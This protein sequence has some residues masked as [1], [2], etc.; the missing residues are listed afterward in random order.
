M[1]AGHEFRLPIHS[2]VDSVTRKFPEK[3]HI[4]TQ[5]V[6]A[7]T[8]CLV[9]WACFATG[10]SD[11]T[12]V[13]GDAVIN[14]THLPQPGPIADP[15]AAAALIQYY[16][17]KNGSDVTGNGSLVN[18]WRTIN[19]AI[20]VLS[21]HGARHGGVCINVRP[22]IYHESVNIGS[23]YYNGYT[24]RNGTLVS[25]N[26][27]TPRG[28]FVLRSTVRHGATIA[29][30]A[31]YD[32]SDG[33][34]FTNASY[35]VVDGFNIVGNDHAPNL[36]A[37]GIN[38]AGS[39]ATVNHSSH[40][41]IM[42]N[43]VHGWGLAGIAS[44]HTDY[45]NVEGNVV[46]GN[47]N[48]SKWGGSGIGVNW[49]P[50]ALN[51]GVWHTGS[52]A[53]AKFHNIVRNNA[54]FHNAEVNIQGQ[55]HW[56][57]N[58][59]ILDGFNANQGANPAYRQPTLVENNVTAYNGGA[60]IITGG[61]GASYVT[62]RNNTSFNNQLDPANR[63]TIRGEIAI[64]GNFG[65]SSHNDIVVNN[66]AVANPKLSPHDSAYV[67]A[68]V[69]RTNP[70]TNNT[71]ACNLSFNGTTGQASI[72][73]VNTTSTFA[74]AHG[75]IPGRNPLFANTARNNFT[76]RNGSPAIGSGTAAYGVPAVDFLGRLRSGSK[77]MGAYSQRG[78]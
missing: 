5:F 17:A 2:I 34:S 70:N 48:T 1:S 39:S 60:G 72:A 27:D 37:T 47:S 3:N 10:Y 11:M 63:A 51:S 36:N 69:S 78:H 77:D 76:L 13:A 46:Y 14:S 20:D 57:G 54:S 38:F 73:F 50:V 58:G 41:I 43:I 56:D 18:P 68:G 23:Q 62:I 19:H 31:A 61:S 75:N 44:E 49:E 32:Y 40:I 4:W 59:I 66:I 74:T 9:A 71:W 67:D 12:A 24:H 65:D 33:F 45:I 29:P 15:Y 30:G 7:A 53:L 35:I 8:T 16:V 64:E 22:G 26:S 55:P 42:N 21:S 25:G 28:Y 52:P 6:T